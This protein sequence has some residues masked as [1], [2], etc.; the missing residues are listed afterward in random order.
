MISHSSHTDLRFQEEYFTS[1]VE[2]E[3]VRAALSGYQGHRSFKK[4]PPLFDDLNLS[5]PQYSAGAVKFEFWKHVFKAAR[6]SGISNSYAT[7]FEALSVLIGVGL[8]PYG[9]T[10]ALSRPECKGVFEVLESQNKLAEVL[11]KAKDFHG[12]K[13]IYLIGQALS[14]LV[15]ERFVDGM[16]FLN[17][18]KMPDFSLASGFGRSLWL[19]ENDLERILFESMNCCPIQ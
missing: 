19:N 9:T 3:A 6:E 7:K 2:L 10:Y 12:E 18:E 15:K 17:Q 4:Y 13:G 11:L 8:T 5:M 14:G 16:V 1:P